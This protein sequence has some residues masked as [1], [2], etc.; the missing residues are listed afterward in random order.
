M[1]KSIQ[2]GFTLIELMIVVAIIGILA[3]IAL[4]AYQDYISKS[5]IT[6][7]VGELAAAKTGVDAGLFDGKKPVIGSNSS[8]LSVAPI[9]LGTQ[10]TGTSVKAS[11]AAVRSNLISK[12]ELK[13]FAAAASGT[14]S[15][16]G[17]SSGSIVATLG[18]KANKDIH[19][20]T[21]AQKR[22][23]NGVWTCE[24]GAGSAA[25]WKDKFIPSGC[26]KV[27]TSSS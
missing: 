2:K 25:G 27:S 16:D 21:V 18:N 20:A 4:P 3:A 12:V 22:D 13:G 14:S 11:G 24:V 8:K 5:Q 9:G 26:T 1:K 10:T 19:T 6:R 17:P 7:V 23:K 15:T